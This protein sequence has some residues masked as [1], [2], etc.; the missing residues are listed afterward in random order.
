[1]KIVIKETEQSMD[2]CLLTDDLELD[3]AVRFDSFDE[4]LA[5]AE[6]WADWIGCQ[7]IQILNA[8]Q[9]AAA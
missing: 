2:V 3:L 4:A 1:M 6:D 8:K 5:F 7:H 9:S